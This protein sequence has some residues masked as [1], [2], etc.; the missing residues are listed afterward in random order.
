ML[1]AMVVAMF[2]SFVALSSFLVDVCALLFPAF[3]LQP[4]SVFTMFCMISTESFR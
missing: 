2:G 1:A 4:V 3:L